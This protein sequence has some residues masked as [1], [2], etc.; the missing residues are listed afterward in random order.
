MNLMTVNYR[1]YEYEPWYLKK[2]Y[3]YIY[4]KMLRDMARP[5]RQVASKTFSA[6]RQ[7]LQ[8]FYPH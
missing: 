1:N 5:R 8:M 2:S 4:I 7:I 3:I 6:K